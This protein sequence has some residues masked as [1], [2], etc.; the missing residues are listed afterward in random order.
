MVAC[1]AVCFSETFFLGF[2]ISVLAVASSLVTAEGL[3]LGSGVI[4][5]SGLMALWLMALWP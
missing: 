3:V 4:A 5:K 1:L 2:L